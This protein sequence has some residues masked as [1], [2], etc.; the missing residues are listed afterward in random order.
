MKKNKYVI[1][2]KEEKVLIV[3]TQNN[4]VVFNT[5]RKALKDCR[6]NEKVIALD[7]LNI[8]LKKQVEIQLSKSKIA[9][10]SKALAKMMEI[11]RKREIIGCNIDAK[12]TNKYNDIFNQYKNI[13]QKHYY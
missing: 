9:I 8:Y 5:K 12:F 4:I 13:C 10:V 1:Y 3:D 11:E 7:N 2:H 6:T